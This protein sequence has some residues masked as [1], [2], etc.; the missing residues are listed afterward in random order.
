MIRTEIFIKNIDYDTLVRIM[1]PYLEKGLTEKDNL[2]TGLFAKIISKDGKPT[3][4]SNLLLS[5]IPKKEDM[6]ACILPHFDELLIE[7]M[8]SQLEKNKIIAR[9]TNLAI[10]SLTGKNGKALRLRLEI[11]SIDYEKTIENL[12]PYLLQWLSEKAHSVGRIGGLLLEWKG[13]P[14]TMVKAAIGVIPVNQ[15]DEIV[16][17]LLTEYRKELKS[18]LN[19][20]LVRNHISA[21]ICKIVI[22]NNSGE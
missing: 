17:A 19:E 9:V 7:L 22:E 4:F 15:R 6:V 16:V 1:M 12:M 14:V 10:D 21:E 2:L 13:L 20:M 8:N 5:L 3:K 18:F 11:N